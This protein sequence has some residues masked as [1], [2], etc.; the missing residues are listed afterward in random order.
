MA[1]AD[2]PLTILYVNDLDRATGFYRDVLRLP[3]ARS[4]PESAQF[5]KS[6][7]GLIIRQRRSGGEEN[8]ARGAHLAFAVDNLDTE[9]NRLTARQVNFMSAP[10]TGEFG[11][12]ATLV[13]PDGN[14]IDLIEWRPEAAGTVTLDSNVN[15]ILNGHPETMEVFEDFGIR[16][17][18]GCLV[19]LNA[20]VYETAEYSGL[21]AGQSAS[22][23]E[24]L[25]AKLEELGAG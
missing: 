12:Q 11:R 21:N 16:I 1:L 22:L 4:S 24:K 13:D 6:G 17:C 3:L 9:C 8:G 14:T 7:G 15:E 25:N 18:G 2:S 5:G 10:A 23:V 19:L 20:P